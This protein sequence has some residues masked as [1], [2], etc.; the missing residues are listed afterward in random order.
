MRTHIGTRWVLGAALVVALVLATACGGGEDASDRGSDGAAPPA[1]SDSGAPSSDEF[2]GGDAKA[3]P[4]GSL[5]SGESY[6]SAGALPAMLDRKIIRTATLSVSVDA[7]S[8]KFEEVSNIALGAGGFVSSSSFGNRGDSQ[9]ASVTIRV[10]ADQYDATLRRLRDLGD[11]KE[12]GS[13]ANDVTEQF[14]DLESRL[15]NLQA[16]EQRYLEFLDR[17]ANITEVLT[18]QDRINATRAEIEQIQGRMQ[19][20]TNQSDLATITVHLLPPGAAADDGANNPLEVA[21]EAF[22]A[23]LV[24]LLGI[25]MVAIAVAAFSWWLVPIAAAGWYLGRK[26]LRASR[27]H[28]S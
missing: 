2:A 6:D 14:T 22:E 4:S 10:P 13:N 12:E 19:L 8:E 25:A 24:V 23:S 16:S 11:V 26:Q 20:L 7:V 18:V 9:T 21:Q 1:A 17:A 28:E 3:P 27:G 5:S 15:R